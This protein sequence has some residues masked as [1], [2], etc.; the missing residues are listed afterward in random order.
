MLA[1]MFPSC[2]EKM[3]S[4]TSADAD[5]ATEEIAVIVEPDSKTENPNAGE[6]AVEPF[7]QYI[8]IQPTTTQRSE[9]QLVIDASSTSFKN[10]DMDKNKIVDA[11]EFYDGFYK[12][13]DADGNNEI[14]EV[15]FNEEE[16]FMSLNN[17]ATL[18]SLAG[19]DTDGNK[20]ISKE[21]LKNKLSAFIDVPNGETLAQHLYCM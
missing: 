15:E 21:E 5:K 4:Q 17:N 16:N 1:F 8:Y 12:L 18:N 3:N 19:W 14:N 7:K 2:S 11:N 10:M 20:I 6:K 13:M 9:S